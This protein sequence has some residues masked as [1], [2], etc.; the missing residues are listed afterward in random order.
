MRLKWPSLANLG[1]TTRLMLWFL[2]ISLI[3]CL[4][5]TLVNNFLSVHSLERSLK[6]QL[7]SISSSKITQL[8]NFIRAR[9][10]DVR[11]ISNTPQTIE[12]TEELPKALVKGAVLEGVRQKRESVYRPIAIHFL[13]AYGYANLYLFDADG[14]L[15]F[16]LKSDLNLG[17]NL[18]EGPLKGTEM[19]EVFERSKM[20]LQAEV[21]DYQ[22]YPGFNEPA[23]FIA[24]PVLTEG[25]VIGVVVLQIG[26][27]E[28]YRVFSDYSGLRETGETLVATR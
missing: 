28:L 9:R 16:R 4:V 25:T 11:V 1:I 3:P 21:S 10:G 26:N 19:A 8:D 15:L 22:V 6:S 18:L 5:L 2:A 20:L 13:E 17:D 24:H 27:S 12:T 7:I 23:V 14:R